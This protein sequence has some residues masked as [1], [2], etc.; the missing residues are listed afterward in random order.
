[1]VSFM[2]GS[3]MCLWRC[4]H[5]DR[6]TVVEMS[7]LN[8]LKLGDAVPRRGNWFSAL[9]GKSILRIRGWT[10]EGAVPNVPKAVVI[11]VPHTSN[12]DFIVGV[13]AVFAM[14]LRASFLGK[15]T[16]F[17]WPFGPMMRW[18]GGVPVDRRTARGVV[19]ETVDLFA[20][21]DQLILGLSP[22]GTRSSVDRWKTGFYYVALEAKVPIIPVAFDYNRTV[23][24]FGERF[25]PTGDIQDDFGRL[26][27]FFSGIEG[28]RRS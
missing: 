4:D 20:A 5:H 8:T 14:G 28:R 2:N 18:L 10:F 19:E 7:G 15:H 26:E 16:L 21:N 24:R 1:M 23:I 27:R 6:Y 22:E 3:R 9:V 12:W 17:K 25:D 11:V 13:A